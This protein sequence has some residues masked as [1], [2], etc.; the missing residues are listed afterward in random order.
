MA[1]AAPD[2]FV[3]EARCGPYRGTVEPKVPP[4]GADHAHHP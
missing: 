3:L 2:T 4:L 1:T